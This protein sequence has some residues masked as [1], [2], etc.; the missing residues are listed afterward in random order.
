VTDPGERVA[1]EAC[2]WIGTP[3]RHQGRRRQV[4]CDCV[5]LLLGVWREVLGHAPPAPDVYSPDW[6]EATG[7]EILLE[8][9]RRHARPKDGW[10]IAAGDVLAFRWRPHL[11]AKHV[12][13]AVS[14]ESFA[15]G[16][17]GAGVC[18]AALEPHWRRR[19]AAIFTLPNDKEG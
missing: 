3:Y 15:H 11:P 7:R 18:L 4:G 19:I 1:A 16:Y 2:R 14:A 9:L 6:A 12:G 17:R 8:A 13:I 10:T 5:G